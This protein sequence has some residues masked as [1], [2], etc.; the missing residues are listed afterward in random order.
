MTFKAGSCTSTPGV[1]DEVVTTTKTGR[2]RRVTV[3][4][5][6]A[7]LSN[8][9]VMSRQHA[10]TGSPSGVA[11]TGCAGFTDDAAYAAMDFLLDALDGIAVEVFGSVAHLQNLVLNI[12]FVDTTSTYFELDLPDELAAL[13][14]KVDGDGVSRPAERASGRSGTPR[15][16][17]PICRRS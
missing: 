12:V 4:G 9:T 6:T 3:L 2:I 7:A 15:T 5:S 17:G 8:T 16:S 11:V 14:D 10:R 1:S 13:Q